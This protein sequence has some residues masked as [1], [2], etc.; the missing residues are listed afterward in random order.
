[1]PVTEA[2]L[3]A[4]LDRLG[5]AHETIRH[6][7]FFT[8]AEGR[9]FKA[10]HPGGHSKNLFLKDKKGALFL[11]VAQAE[12]AVDLKAL[13]RRVARGRLSFGAPDRLRE[14]LGVAPGSVTPFALLND[15]QAAVTAI[16][17]SALLAHDPIYF[18]PLANTA[19]TAISPDGLLAF[20]RATGRA[21]LIVDLARPLAAP[22]D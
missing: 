2:D 7:P 4:F 13:S 16:V 21:P 22:N 9:A 10:G 17:D 6:P 14:A 12:T 18:H 5:V 15:P 3:F 1:M 11:V 19:S 8:V 20:I